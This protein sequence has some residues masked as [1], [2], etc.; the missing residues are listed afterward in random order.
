MPSI[1]SPEELPSL[2]TLNQIAADYW[3]LSE[4]EQI[5][6]ET[7][8]QTEKAPDTVNE[9]ANLI[10]GPYPEISNLTIYPDG[11]DDYEFGEA[12]AEELGPS[13]IGKENCEEFFDYELFGR[14]VKMDESGYD[15]DGDYLVIGDLSLDSSEPKMEIDLFERSEDESE[16]TAPDLSGA[17]AKGAK[18]HDQKKSDPGPDKPSGR[19][20]AKKSKPIPKS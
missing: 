20:T 4:A 15:L 6:L 11:A 18:A 16:R 3:D 19:S 17:I 5:Q 12:L 8:S 2:S 7:L 9:L 10:H 13:G 1:I 14:D